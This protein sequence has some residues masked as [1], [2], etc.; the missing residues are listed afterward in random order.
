MEDSAGQ[1]VGR[2]RARMK[3]DGSS[4]YKNLRDH[5][6]SPNHFLF[7]FDSLY[8]HLTFNNDAGKQK[9]A[10]LLKQIAEIFSAPINALYIFGSDMLC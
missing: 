9:D 8:P 4:V 2:S 7:F 1:A 3:Y 6:F 10:E 5:L